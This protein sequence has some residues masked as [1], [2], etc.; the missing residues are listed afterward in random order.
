MLKACFAMCF[1]G[2]LVNIAHIISLCA[3]NGFGSFW[4]APLGQKMPTVGVA[5]A[6]SVFYLIGMALALASIPKWYD[7]QDAIKDEL[8]V[9]VG[10]VFL[11]LALIAAIASAVLSFLGIG[12][13]E[14]VPADSEPAGN[15]P[16]VEAPVDSKLADNGPDVEPPA[17]SKPTDNN[18]DVAPAATEAQTDKQA[19]APPPNAGA[20]T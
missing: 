7:H 6:L 15:R 10:S 5:A 2:L 18:P 9:G 12:P 17:D 13:A 1:I 4:P 16:D 8:K 19:D 3:A 20:A 11:I 14:V